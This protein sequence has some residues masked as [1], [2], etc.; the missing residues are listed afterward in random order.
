MKTPPLITRP[1]FKML[2]AFICFHLLYINL[3]YT[4]SVVNIVGV[5]T[6]V[7]GKINKLDLKNLT[8]NVAINRIGFDQENIELTADS[9]GDFHADFYLEVATDVWI[10]YK[11]NFLAIVKPGDSLFVEFNGNAKERPT[12]LKTIKF[13]GQSALLNTEIAQFQK[14]YFGERGTNHF[15]KR[16]KI[17]KNYSPEEFL[18]YL[19][20]VKDNQAKLFAN[21][22]AEYQPSDEAKM[23]AQNTMAGWWRNTNQRRINYQNL[24]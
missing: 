7:S 23:W 15:K 3:A 22:V 18:I 13:S 1:I 19:Q 24:I 14:R 9:N 17:Y 5:K 11:T 12:L 6:Q 21:Y 20:K 2:L 16:E 8:V 4:Q 10:V